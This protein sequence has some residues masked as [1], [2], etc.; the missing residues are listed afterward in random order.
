MASP[1]ALSVQPQSEPQVASPLATLP[2]CSFT[3]ALILS[4][5]IVL[6]FLFHPYKRI[7]FS[8][9]TALLSATGAAVKPLRVLCQC[10]DIRGTCPKA[11]DQIAVQIP[12]RLCQAVPH[13]KAF[14]AA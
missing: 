4:L 1:S 8:K 6:S 11:T 9:K 2:Y 14:L 3:A 10:L 5:S 13:P 12:Y 7:Y